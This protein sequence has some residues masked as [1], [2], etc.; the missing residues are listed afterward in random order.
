MFYVL[1]SYDYKE[2]YSKVLLKS[3]SNIKGFNWLFQETL[4][5]LHAGS[6]LQWGVMKSPG[7]QG[8]WHIKGQW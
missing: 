2:N 6:A 3:G 5:S 7:P 4:S 1:P 8:S